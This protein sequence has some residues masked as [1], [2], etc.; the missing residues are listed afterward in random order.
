MKLD[1]LAY[2]WIEFT[3]LN[4]DDPQYH[5]KFYIWEEVYE[6]T[7]S[8]FARGYELILS[9]LKQT[10][11]ELVLANLAAGPIEDLLSNFANDGLARLTK[12]VKKNGKLKRTLQGVWQGGMNDS[13]WKL[14]NQIRSLD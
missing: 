3:Q 6:I 11:D 4:K 14:F 5:I 10:E 12:D 13:E 9:I 7:H 1:E 2:K 8:D